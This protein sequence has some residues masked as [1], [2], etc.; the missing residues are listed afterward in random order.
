MPRGDLLGRET[1]GIKVLQETSIPFGA[2]QQLAREMLRGERWSVRG[3][4]VLAAVMRL[5]VA[6]PASKRVQSDRIHPGLQYAIVPQG[7]AAL[8]S[9]HPG[10]LS[11]LRR[12]IRRQPPG[13]QKDNRSGEAA[14][15]SAAEL[16]AA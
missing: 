3:L 13:P 1:P 12:G 10:R 5:S 6:Q 11:K 9:A 4:R 7:R 8:P 16:V 2:S 14:L 15:V